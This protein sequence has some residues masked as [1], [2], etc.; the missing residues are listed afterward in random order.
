MRRVPSILK[1]Q[2]LQRSG[3]RG[4]QFGHHG[5]GDLPR[6]LRADGQADGTAHRRQFRVGHALGAQKGID[7]FALGFAA[8]HA[9]VGG[10]AGQGLGQSLAVEAV[11]A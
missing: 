9:D 7:L 3:A 6:R 1:T 11:P 10:V 4:Q 8:D 5:H 2:A